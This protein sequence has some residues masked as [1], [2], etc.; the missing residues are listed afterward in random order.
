MLRDHYEINIVIFTLKWDENRPNNGSRRFDMNQ[1]YLSDELNRFID[2]I[3][4]PICRVH[5]AFH[6]EY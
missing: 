1:K 6:L 5:P 3:T 2:A 4:A